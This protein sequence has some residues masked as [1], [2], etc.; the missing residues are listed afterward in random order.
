MKMS[1]R[2]PFTLLTKTD[3]NTSK[4]V[5][6]MQCLYTYRRRYQLKTIKVFLEAQSC[7][8]GIHFYHA[9]LHDTKR[10][11]I[12]N[13]FTCLSL[14]KIVPTSLSAVGLES[15]IRW[16]NTVFISIPFFPVTFLILS[17]K[18]YMCVLDCVCAE[19]SKTYYGFACYFTNG[20]NS[21]TTLARTSNINISVGKSV[22][23]LG[24]IRF[25]AQYF[26]LLLLILFHI[27][28]IVEI[29]M[30]NLTSADI[31]YHLF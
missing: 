14:D 26:K 8:I 10:S 6:S 22:A 24:I 30:L 13:T 25:L 11:A 19:V 7:F 20:F 9:C 1:K 27:Y 16:R 4:S 21:I 15:I 28:D 29:R 12:I 2:V 3:V 18:V 23:K 5:T 17:A 31:K